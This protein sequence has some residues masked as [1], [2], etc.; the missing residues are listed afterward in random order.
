VVDPEI[1]RRDVAAVTAGLEAVGFDLDRLAAHAGYSDRLDRIA[2]EQLGDFF[3]RTWSSAITL[4]GGDVTLP[5]A[6]GDAVPF[7]AYE[8]V[9]YL[10]S[11]CPT[12]GSGLTE[13]ARYFGLVTPKL[14]WTLD[15]GHDPPLV[16][17]EAIDTEP[18]VAAVALQYTIGV[19]FGR[20][21]RLTAGELAFASVDLSMPAPVDDSRHRAFFAAPVRY[22]APRTILRLPRRVWTLPLERGEPVLRRILERHARTLLA[23]QAQAEEP[24]AEVRAAVRARLDDGDLKVEAVA[25]ELATSARTLQR[26][27]GE[28]GTS[29]QAI[30]DDE[31]RR[32]AE[33]YLREARLAVGDVAYMLGYS[34]PSA[35][36]R[37]FKRW[38]GTTPRA[39]R[40]RA[41]G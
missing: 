38:T 9:D 3:H 33:S 12:V 26:R 20:F 36:V 4:S 11:S 34:E 6:V 22:G 31:R 41:L 37:A 24:L 28:A 27:L 14:R 25:R 8:I 1:L 7:G 5:L 19:T 2:V 29:F 23:Q 10:A 35:F 17:L 15:A 32:A 16:F 39:Y 30:V 40:L 18:E 13:L 21:R